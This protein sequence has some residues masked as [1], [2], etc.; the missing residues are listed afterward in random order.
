M[1]KYDF[2]VVGAG[3]SGTTTAA[4]LA[5]KG[6]TVLLLEKAKLPRYK[7]SGGGILSRAIPLFPIPI[8]HLYDQS[9][10]LAHLGMHDIAKEWTVSSRPR[11]MATVMRE[12]LDMALTEY[13]INKGAT[14][15]DKTSFESANIHTTHVEIRTDQGVFEARYLIGADGVYSRVA[16]TLFPNERLQCCAAS[17]WEIRPTTNSS[18][19][20]ILPYPRFD[21]GGIRGGYAWAFPKKTQ[22]SVGALTTK[23]GVNLPH[24][25]EQYLKLLKL[26]KFEILRKGGHP[27]PYAMRKKGVAIPRVLL[28]GDAAGLADP[29]TFEGLTYALLS[30]RL[31]TQTVADHFSFPKVVADLYQKR[32]Q[33]EI[34][35]EMRAAQMMSQFLYGNGSIRRFLFKRNGDRLTKAMVDVAMGKKS[36]HTDLFSIKNVLKIFFQ[37]KTKSSS[38][39]S[40]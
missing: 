14:L 12:N 1:K 27:I 10:Q 39:T 33:D 18:E 13:A 11:L 25:I 31:A 5:Q 23:R 38:L 30:A 4:L 36:Y 28:T 35:Q 2:C 21:F 16:K 37:K 7:I 6:Y 20:S 22:I 8:D 29:I 19:R 17:E 15:Q 34:G 3:P 24:A 9:F 32:I 40:P 26:E